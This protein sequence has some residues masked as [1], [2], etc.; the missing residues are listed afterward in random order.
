MATTGVPPTQTSTTIGY[1]SSYTNLILSLALLC[2]TMF[3]SSLIYFL[4]RTAMARTKRDQYYRS[5]SSARFHE[6]LHV[7]KYWQCHPVRDAV[8]ATLASMVGLAI[9]W[10]Y[11][12]FLMHGSPC[13]EAGLCKGVSDLLVRKCFLI[14][15][16]PVLA[17]AVAVANWGHLMVLLWAIK[18]KRAP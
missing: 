18:M 17:G 7:P 9:G 3:L 12:S 14:M 13:A 5:H 1:R 10:V 16:L 4:V 11:G 15:L 2:Y 6:A 8:L